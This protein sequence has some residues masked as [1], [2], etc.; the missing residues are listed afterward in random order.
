MSFAITSFSRRRLLAS[1]ASLTAVA[2]FASSSCASPQLPVG[3]YPLRSRV[4]GYEMQVLL[5][6]IPAPTYEHAGETYVLGQL[7]AR[8]TVR[9]INHT[10]RRIE[11]V[12]SVDGRDAVDGKTA[13]VRNKRGYVVPAW[14]SFDI[15]GWR[16]SHAQVAAFRFSSV[17]DSYAARTGS[18]RDVGVIGVALFPERYV[19]PPRPLYVPQQDWG[20]EPPQSNPSPEAS[21]AGATPPAR[22][23]SYANEATPQDAR[24]SAQSKAPPAAPSAADASGFGGRAQAQAERVRAP[25][26]RP[27]LGTEFGEAV[28]SRVEEVSFM[29]ANP[30]QPAVILGAR[31]NDRDGLVALGINLDGCCGPDDDL[32]W[33]QTATP[34]S[35]GDRRYAAPP[36]GWRPGCCVRY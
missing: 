19:R 36:S 33:R 22:R 20:F 31:Y 29:R 1:I 11:A 16:L 9:V 13:D 15:D 28:G 5:D 2:G 17:A 7:G 23:E 3:G 14:G 6:G 21:A 25:R 32:A 4:A 12:A 35:G 27:G 10:G 18:A 26:S 24:A 30:S 8:Y 34:F